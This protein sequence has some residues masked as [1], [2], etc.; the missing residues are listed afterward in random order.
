MILPTYSIKKE[1]ES[2]SVI[3]MLTEVSAINAHAELYQCLS[4]GT[5]DANGLL[6]TYGVYLEDVMSGNVCV[7]LAS[8]ECD[9]YNCEIKI[10]MSEDCLM[11]KESLFSIKV[12]AKTMIGQSLSSPHLDLI[13][14]LQ[15]TCCCS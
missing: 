12:F 14:E 7:K 2:L 6:I 5:F 10:V 13:S 9:V 1:L 4:Q 15:A 8:R 3:M 11:K